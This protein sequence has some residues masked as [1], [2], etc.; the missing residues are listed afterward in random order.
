M[1]RNWVSLVPT[2]LNQQKPNH[3]LE[4]LRVAWKN[5]D[6]LPFAWRILA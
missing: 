4:M 1:F 3:Y 6:E 5:R 2:G